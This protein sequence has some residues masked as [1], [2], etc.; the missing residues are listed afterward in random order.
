MTSVKT[1]NAQHPKNVGATVQTINGRP[2]PPK[3]IRKMA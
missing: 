2:S 3:K 1:I